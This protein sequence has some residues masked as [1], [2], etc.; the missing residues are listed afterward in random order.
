MRWSDS[1]ITEVGDSLLNKSIYGEE[2]IITRAVGGYGTVAADDLVKMT[3]LVDQKQD[4]IL[5]GMENVIGGK[6]IKIQVRNTNLAEG[7]TLQQIGVYARL[8]GEDTEIL[9][10]VLQDEKGMDI[11][12]AYDAPDFLFEIYAAMGVS[13][14]ANIN[15]KVDS[16]AVVSPGELD[17]RLNYF[18]VVSNVKPT[19]YPAIWFDTTEVEQGSETVVLALEEDKDASVSA[20][21][22]GTNYAVTNADT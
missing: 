17:A 10:F 3:E 21:I 16:S 18:F 6:K 5:L 8:E 14:S 13:N 20:V 11:P 4:L 9:L 22:D 19:A 12:T 2:L 15:I 1:S 7:Y